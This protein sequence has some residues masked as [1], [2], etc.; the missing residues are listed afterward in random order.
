MHAMGQ[1]HCKTSFS[2]SEWLYSDMHQLLLQCI[3][4]NN[5]ADLGRW[6]QSPNGVPHGPYPGKEFQHGYGSSSE[7]ESS[8]DDAA[9]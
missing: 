7:D 6:D 1:P 5:Q 9:G 3:A 8:E 2:T 4:L